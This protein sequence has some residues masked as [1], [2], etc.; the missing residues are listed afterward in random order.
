MSY[1]QKEVT[2]N[3]NGFSLERIFCVSIENDF[4]LKHILVVIHG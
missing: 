3:S 2:I 1:E 4:P